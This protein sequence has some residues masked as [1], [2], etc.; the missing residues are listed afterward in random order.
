[1][2][3]TPDADQPQL[4]LTSFPDADVAKRIAS[5]LVEEKLAACVSL[6]PGAHSVYAWK[7]GVESAE[8]CLALVKTHSGRYCELERRLVEL[9][10]YDVP[11]VLAIDIAAG[12]P[13]YVKWLGES[14]LH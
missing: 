7:G 2:T 5:R 10:P 11:E 4:V 6:L 14:L 12:A 1:M 9:H 8:E 3:A 13:A